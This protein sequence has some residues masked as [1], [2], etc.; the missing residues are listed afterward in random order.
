MSV[1]ELPNRSP[2]F[3]R[4]PPHDVVAEQGVLGGMMLSKDAIA[5]V[6]ELLRGNDF[7]RPA[8]ESGLLKV[9][10]AAVALGATSIERHVTL[11][12]AMYGS[13]QAASIEANSLRNFAASVRAIPA[14]LGTGIKTLTEKEVS[15]RNKLR[16]NING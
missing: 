6:V 4:V 2:E 1:A 14:I 8:H 9:C 11:D 3:E 7:Y 15:A 5:D 16:I 12:R 10:A 13:D